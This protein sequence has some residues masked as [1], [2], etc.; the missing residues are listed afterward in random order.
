MHVIVVFL[1]GR[2]GGG[3]G[4]IGFLEKCSKA[5]ILMVFPCKLNILTVVFRPSIGIIGIQFQLSWEISTS[6]N[7]CQPHSTSPHHCHVHK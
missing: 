4:G 6:Y 5:V 1:I 3:R 7:S 2:G